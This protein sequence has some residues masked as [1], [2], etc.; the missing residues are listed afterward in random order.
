MFDPKTL[1]MTLLLLCAKLLGLNT[2]RSRIIWHPF[3]LETGS[4]E[5][6]G[7][8]LFLNVHSGD[9]YGNCTKLLDVLNHPNIDGDYNRRS[10]AHILC[11]SHWTHWSI[12]EGP[13]GD[14]GL[15]LLLIW[16]HGGPCVLIL[17]HNME[18]P[19]HPGIPPCCALLSFGVALRVRVA[20]LVLGPRPLG[21]SHGRVAL[22]CH[23][24]WQVCARVGGIEDWFHHHCQPSPQW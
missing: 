16:H 21:G 12:A 3:G 2:C 11:A 13:S 10:G 9:E 18:G 8:G 4:E 14:V 5:G 22:L 1:R 19:L 7:F 6:I 24:Q 20:P 15:L 17:D 23:S